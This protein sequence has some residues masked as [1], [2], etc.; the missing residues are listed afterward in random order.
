MSSSLRVL[1]YFAVVFAFSWA[2]QIPGILVLRERLEP[3]AVLMLMMALGSAGP[4]LVALGFRVL[5][6]RRPARPMRKYQP[7]LPRWQISLIALAHLAVAQLIGSAIL[8]ALGKYTA[9]HVMY[10]PLRP[11]QIAIAIIA[12]LGEEFGWRGY[13]LPRLQA[14]LSPLAASLC[15][16][17]PWALWHI[18]TFFVPEARGTTPFELCMYLVAFIASSVIYTWLF[19]A[20]GGSILGPL[21]AHL[22]I[23]LDNVF[24]AS[25]MGDGVLPLAMTSLVLSAMAAALVL[26]GRMSSVNAVAYLQPSAATPARAEA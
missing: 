3:P 6:G 15:V 25:M 16:A 1:V 11:E 18:P 26:T 21:L 7:L 20:G 19:N 10:P 22:G 12:P 23:H 4:S 17:L 2:C 5:E 8:L 24:R 13:A 9:Q 14:S